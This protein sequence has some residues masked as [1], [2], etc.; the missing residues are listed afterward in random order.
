[1]LRFTVHIPALNNSPQLKEFFRVHAP[2][3]PT[4]L[5]P[6]KPP[7]PLCCSPD[8]LLVF[9]SRRVGR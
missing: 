1:L 7:C 4:S 5:G 9:L 2:A 8:S 6:G 3:L